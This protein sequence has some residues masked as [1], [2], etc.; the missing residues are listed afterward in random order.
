MT[1]LITSSSEWQ[2]YIYIYIYIY[3]STFSSLHHHY[4][5]KNNVSPYSAFIIIPILTIGSSTLQL[6][7]WFRCHFS[8]H[9]YTRSGRA[10]LVLISDV[11]YSNHCAALIPLHS[12]VLNDVNCE[13]L[14]NCLST[15]L[16]LMLSS[17]VPPWAARCTQCECRVSGAIKNCTFKP[18][19]TI[20]DSYHDGGLTLPH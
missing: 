19:Y 17:F 1:M 16:E 20:D 18:P 5:S 9:D 3:A 6:T 13:R 10:E 7:R 2:L 14:N 15:W 12:V 8:L 4:G 11:N